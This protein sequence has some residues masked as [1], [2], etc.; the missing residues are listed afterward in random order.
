MLYACKDAHTLFTGQREKEGG[1][2]REREKEE[3]NEECLE[4]VRALCL[5]GCTHT[6]FAAER[7]RER[8]RERESNF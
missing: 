2:E 6:L 3:E 4:C 5:Q 1:R 8:E 7:E